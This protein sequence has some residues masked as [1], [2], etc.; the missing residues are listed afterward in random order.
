M[1]DQSGSHINNLSPEM[2][3]PS[4]GP[5]ITVIGV[6]ASAGGLDA[7]RKFLNALP[8][9]HGIAFIL[10]QHLDP[11]HDSMLVELLTRYT[12]MTVVQATDGMQ[13]EAN[14]LYAIP[15]GSYLSVK[16]DHLCLSPPQAPRGAR[17]PFDFLLN[18][19][20]VEYGERA[21]GVILSGTGTD[22]NLGAKAIKSKNGLIIAQ[23]PKDAEYD[24]MPQSAITAQVVDL[25]LP[26]GEIP[27]A[28][29]SHIQNPEPEEK[30][31]APLPEQE[32]DG[33]PKIIDLLK[34]GTGHDFSQYKQGTIRR[35]IERRML[36]NDIK[37]EDLN[38]YLEKL[39]KDKSELALLSSD[40]LINVTKFFRDSATAEQLSTN[41]IPELVHNHSTDQPVRVWTA[42]CSTG[43]EAYSLAILFHEQIEADGRDLKLQI[44]AS[45]IDSDA[46]TTA[47]DG[48]Y[49]LT[50]EADMTAERL[51]KNFIKEKNGYRVN[52]D[53][54]SLVVFSVH[55]LLSDPPFS[56]IDFISCRNLLIYMVPEAQAKIISIFHFSLRDEGI[57]LLGS[58]ETTGSGEERFKQISKSERIYQNIGGSRLERNTFPLG[59]GKLMQNTLAIEPSRAPI[60]QT[61]LAE[62]CRRLALETYVPAVVLTNPQHECLYS[63][64]ATDRY[65]RIPPGPPTRDLLSMT[66]QN[67]RTK[68]RQAIEQACK[69]KTRCVANPTG[70]K[71]DGDATPFSITVQP[72]QNDGKQLLLVSFQDV[73]KLPQAPETEVV[74]EDMGRV[75]E[76]ERELI[77]TKADLE[78]AI[79]RL[80]VST[81]EQKAINDE[82]LSVNEEF[83]S[84]NEELLA[85]KEEL[86]SLNEELTALNSQLQ[87]TL[88]RQRTTSNDLQNVLYSTD[89]A[90]IFLDTA[91]NIR[92]FT[93]ATRS[94]FSVI[95]SDIGRPLADLNSLAADSTLLTDANA[96]LKD[97]V[98]QEREIEAKCGSWFSRRILPYRTQES[99]VEGVVITF[100]DITERRHAAVALEDAERQAQMANIAKSRFLAAASH[101]LRQPLQALALFQGLL[102]KIVVGEKAVQLVERLDETLTAMSGI[103]NTLLDINQI[104]AGAVHPDICSFPISPLLEQIGNEFDFHA[105]A[106]GISLHVVPCSL[107]VQS[108]F[109]LLEQ[110]IRNFLSN[111]FKYTKTGKILLGCRRKG[112]A[113]CIEIHDTG[114]GIADGEREK[115]FEEYHQI[116]NV[117][118]ERSLGLGLGLSIVKRLTDL[119]G[120]PIRVQSRLGKG[121]AFI[122]EV[123]L[124]QEGSSTPSAPASHDKD[125]SLA[126][127]SQ[128]SRAC[129]ILVVE[130]D[131][132]VRELLGLLLKEEG[133]SATTA[134]DGLTA[135]DLVASAET[136]PSLVLADYNLPNGMNGLQVIGALRRSLHQ[137]IPAIILTGDVSAKTIQN[138]ALNDC[139]QLNKPVKLKELSSAI[140]NLLTEH[141][142]HPAPYEAPHVPAIAVPAPTPASD[143]PSVASD[144]TIIFIVDDDASVRVALRAV[145]EDDGK[146]VEDFADC[147]SFLDKYRPGGECCL[148][149][150]AI[151]PGMDGFTLLQHL[152]ASG[153]QIPLIMITGHG[154]VSMA[155]KA[156]KAGASDFIEK[157]IKRIELLASVKRALERSRDSS[158]H[159]AWKETAARQISGL[160]PRQRQIMKMILAGNPNKNIAADLG[161]SQRTVETHRA[162][163]MRK[164]GAKSLPALARLALAASSDSED[165]ALV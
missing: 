27:K 114:I 103:L 100:I 48:L 119:L 28:I 116:D 134:P 106:Q 121:S 71:Q 93:P 79:H 66:P 111:A 55:D 159:A 84:T 152:S 77:G 31:A 78:D 109:R 6:G 102:A 131:P 35:R 51:A 95:P 72:V 41:I 137:Q 49:P 155:V 115:I 146:T 145:L 61:S 120:H 130:D 10:I 83:Q 87:E 50:I 151:L 58:S 46:I 81:E 101:D 47:R 69:D 37:P 165:E 157:P 1:Q 110:I 136:S 129:Q 67:M 13:I 42:G 12:S 164:T 125:T 53:L 140:Q 158:K 9:E 63:L 128:T 156:M 118:R 21:I 32:S 161:I 160:T 97:A 124:C 68:L 62:L 59:D 36:M 107:S 142:V 98:P 20:A 14:H 44:L 105:Q 90:T 11:T 74:S 3:A 7:F 23:D 54:R 43:E 94:L 30:P 91:L 52:S 149:L 112:K 82:A 162:S 65:L 40:L 141:P 19:L 104:E 117:A 26:V 89:V 34:T 57:L 122:I 147:Q 138:V 133:Y 8:V 135:L 24:G 17:L 132:E 5:P 56:R 25:V 16:N 88:E 39:Q 75:A 99:G 148:L 150:D 45:D 144:G 153:H 76:L 4:R 73:P 163:I 86:Q 123:P 33:F 108:D 70:V 18:S 22:G 15:P 96:V 154:D 143:L 2:L 113:L 139:I 29:L 127:T 92:F 64:G 60:Q 126:A 80:E 85:S 38:S